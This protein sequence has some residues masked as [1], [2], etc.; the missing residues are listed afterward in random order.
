MFDTV[1]TLFT[2][3]RALFICLFCQEF[4]KVKESTLCVIQNAQMHFYFHM[5]IH[6]SRFILM[7][8][9]LIC[10]RLAFL[11]QHLELSGGTNKKYKDVSEWKVRG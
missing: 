5:C 11:N 10:C 3:G 9:F 6:H 4:S 8:F 7:D 1:D 2:D